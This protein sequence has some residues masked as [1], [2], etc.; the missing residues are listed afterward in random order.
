MDKDGTKSSET[1]KFDYM[2]PDKIQQ[3][4]P[5][6]IAE[7][8]KNI[9]IDD[10]KNVGK[11]ACFRGSLLNG[12]GGGATIGALRYIQKGNILSAS[13]W[14]GI[15]QEKTATATRKH[16]GGCTETK[17]SEKAKSTGKSS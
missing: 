17:R 1:Q 3:P 2:K 13:N 5:S 11:M 7:I 4:R 12:I 15:L 8:M 9:S 10:F 14:A 6:D 16:A